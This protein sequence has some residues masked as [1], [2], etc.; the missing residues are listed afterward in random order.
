MVLE[1]RRASNPVL[2][3]PAD[4]ADLNVLMSATYYTRIRG[5][6]EGPFDLAEL[7]RLAQ[8]GRL[9]R[10]HQISTD[11]DTW[12]T[13]GAN[14]SIFTPPARTPAATT[15][16][17]APKAPSPRSSEDDEFVLLPLDS[18]S[19]PQ[20]PV[21]PP[22]MPAYPEF[23][24][25]RAANEPPPLPDDGFIELIPC[26]EP[27]INLIPVNE[28]PPQPVN[29]AAMEVSPR[30]VDAENDRFFCFHEGT[31][32]GPFTWRLLKAMASDKVLLPETPVWRSG[33]DQQRHPARD[34]PHLMP[35]KPPTTPR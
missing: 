10:F 9:S 1:R 5:N 8:T 13:A 33:E 35:S 15:S 22:V 12:T 6:V 27:V 30:S 31:T 14:A 29:F 25:S 4:H 19:A 11:G 7:R 34:W 16:P 2:L 32:L 21:I 26:D 20:V 24:P 18:P 17:V 3:Q 23:R 28:A